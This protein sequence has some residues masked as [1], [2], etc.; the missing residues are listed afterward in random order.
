MTEIESQVP[1][2]VRVAA[3]LEVRLSLQVWGQPRFIIT[4]EKEAFL[5]LKQLISFL[6]TKM[7]LVN[8]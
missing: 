5:S 7:G 4:I 3:R 1:Q 6:C 8:E 2:A